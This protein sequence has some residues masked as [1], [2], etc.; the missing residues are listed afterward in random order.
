MFRG[1]GAKGFKT[2]FRVFTPLCAGHVI[3][4]IQHVLIASLTLAP[5]IVFEEL[6]LSATM[7][8]DHFVNVIQ[9]PIPQILSRAMQYGHGCA[10]SWCRRQQ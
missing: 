1:I 2:L 10:R 3:P 7:H 9:L 6:D 5:R 4:R 8:A